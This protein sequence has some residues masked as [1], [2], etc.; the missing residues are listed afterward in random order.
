MRNVHEESID[1]LQLYLVKSLRTYILPDHYGDQLSPHP[2]VLK[3]HSLRVLDFVKREN[4]SSS[5]GL[6]K[7]LRY[8]NLSGGGFET[9]PGSLFKLWNLQIL[10]LDRCRRLKMLP[11]SLICLK[12]LQQLSFNGCQE[13]SR[14]PPQIGKLTSLRILTKFFVGKERGFCLEELG[15]QKLKGDLDIKHLGNVKSVMDAKEANMSRLPLLGKLPSLK[16]IRIQNM[17]HVEYFYQESYDGEVVFRAL[18]DLSLRQLPNLKMLSRQYGENMFPRFSILEIDGCPKFLGEEVLLHRLHSLSVIS[19]G[20]FNLS[21]GFKCLQKLWISECKG[22]KNLQAL[23]YM[24]SLK[25]IRLRNLH[26]LESLPDCF[27]NLSLLHTLSIF[28]CS[29]LTCLPMS[30]SLSGEIDRGFRI[31]DKKYTKCY[32]MAEFVLETVLRNLNSLVQKELALFLGFDQDLERLTTLSMWNV[33]GES[34][35]SVP[36]H[37]VKSLRTYILPDHYGDQLSP[38]PDVLKCL[39]LRVLDFVK[40][41]TLSSSIEYLYEESCDGEVVFRALKV[42]TIRHLPNFKRLSRE[43]GENMFPR[44][45]NLEIDE[46]PKF[47]G[48]EEL[49]KGLE[50]LSVFNCDKFNVSA[51][52]QRLWK[53]WISNCRE[54]G[55]LQALQ[56]MTS[57]KVLRLRSLPELESLPDCFGNL[58]LLCELIQSRDNIYGLAI[59]ATIM[60]LVVSKFLKMER[61][62]LSCLSGDCQLYQPQ[63]LILQKN[64][65][66]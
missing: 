46:C 33:Y 43:D 6:L 38:L 15:S 53:L 51:G 56:D 50:C 42:L 10:K 17:I 22:V 9:L 44:L 57:L 41:E 12:A 14:L 65:V 23:Q 16:T 29:K 8:L 13:L 24:T 26:E 30:L 20:K 3:C 58:P 49:L 34:I 35:N 19:C 11:N 48:D 39:S 45:S 28:H 47:L 31:A 61:N 59:P 2:D 4:L 66:L 52:F 25:E 62:G 63:L 5:I 1:A 37:L 18:E 54:V 55:D 36:L 64:L 60:L 27:G 32:N 7:H 40:R 21:A